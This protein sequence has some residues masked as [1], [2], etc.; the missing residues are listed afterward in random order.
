MLFKEIVGVVKPVLTPFFIQ[1]YDGVVPP[2][3]IL[4]VKLHDALTVQTVKAERAIVIVGKHAMP[5]LT[6]PNKTN[7][8]KKII[9]RALRYFTSKIL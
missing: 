1:T 9:F 5:C 2:N 7:K 4:E 3:V 6:A 8:V